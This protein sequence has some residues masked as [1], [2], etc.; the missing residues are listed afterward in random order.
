MYTNTHTIFVGRDGKPRDWTPKKGLEKLAAEWS[1][2]E[3]TLT[4]DDPHLADY[5]PTNTMWAWVLHLRRRMG[6]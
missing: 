6:L 2:P 1:T 3:H 4:W 5:A